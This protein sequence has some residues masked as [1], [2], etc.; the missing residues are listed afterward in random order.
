[1][2]MLA[3]HPGPLMYTRIFLRLEPLGLELVAQAARRAGHEVR[4]FDLQVEKERDFHHMV[5]EWQPDVVA[6]SCNY[7]ANVP[8]IVDLAQSAKARLPRCFI[9]VGGHSASFVAAEFLEHAGGAI[10]CILRG[11]GEATIERLLWAVEQDRASISRIPGVVTLDGE[12]P[13]PQSLHSLDDVSPARDLLRHRHKYFLGVLDPCASVEFTRG[14]P[15]DCSFCSAW[16]F[17]GR[18]YRMM[19]PERVVEDVARIREPGIFIVD[20]VAFI[21]A[22]HGFAIGEAIARQGI[23]KQYYLETRG[24]VLLRN[25]E[26]FQFWKRL[27][28]EY[29]FLGIEAID[30]EGLHQHRKRISVGKNFEALEFARS[31][32]IRVAINLIA[33]P[34]WDRKR[35]AIVREWCLDIPEIVTISVNTP[36]PGTESWHTESRRVTTRDYRLYDIQHAVLPTRLPL[37]DFYDELVKTQQVL[38]KK[39][40]GWAALK[41]TASIAAGHLL[42]GQTNFVKMLWKFNSVYDPKLQLADHQR[43]PRYEMTLPSARQE[44]IDPQL[45]YIL[46]AKG[47]QGRALDDAT[48]AFVDRSRADARVS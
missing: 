21:Q 11:E 18:S 45:L 10:E 29:M 47:R 12:G 5:A 32:G 9:L 37:P 46:P 36:Y 27:G 3:V 1:M 22:K 14:C 40:L 2:K 41:S 17:Y 44:H 28:L 16:T 13:P 24:D 7:L 33:D 4:V 43:A 39:H 30:E 31:L 8:E 48:E 42:H 19:S 15:W 34:D 20:D 35:F 25:K 6:F 38:N 26:V 23:K